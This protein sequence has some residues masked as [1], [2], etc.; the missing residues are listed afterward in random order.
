VPVQ[1]PLATPGVQPLTLEQLLEDV[2]VAG[3]VE[4][5]GVPEHRGPGAKVTVLAGRRVS[6]DLQ[7]ICPVQSELTSQYCV[8]HVLEQ[9]PSQQSGVVP[10][11]SEDCV[12]SF[13]QAVYCVLMQSPATARLGSTFC[14]V[15]QQVSPRRSVSQSEEV[16]HDL[17]HLVGLVQKGSS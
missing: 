14:K 3:Q 1:T 10:P 16:L 5:L 2:T 4:G 7:Q 12:H 11:Q 8:L 6:A 13:G 17:A 15:V 9:T